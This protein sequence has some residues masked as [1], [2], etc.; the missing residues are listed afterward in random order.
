MTASVTF[1]FYG[2]ESHHCG[3]DMPEH[4]GGGGGCTSAQ[5]RWCRTSTCSRWDPY[6]VWAPPGA[7]S[8]WGWP[9]GAE[10][11]MGQVNRCGLIPDVE[12]GA[13]R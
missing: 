11:R 5:A 9:E 10:A 7:G 6:Q 12:K 13:G 8:P 4:G 3:S 2:Q 1:V